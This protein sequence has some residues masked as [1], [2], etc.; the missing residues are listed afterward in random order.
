MVLQQKYEDKH[1]KKDR[2][3][4]ELEMGLEKMYKN[5]EAMKFK[6]SNSTSSD[7][8]HLSSDNHPDRDPTD[9]VRECQLT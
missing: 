7:R 5:S 9:K 2:K 3:I 8:K 6:R 4:A 1:I